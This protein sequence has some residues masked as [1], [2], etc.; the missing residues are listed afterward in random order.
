MTAG[1]WPAAAAAATSAPLSAAV[2]AAMRTLGHLLSRP[3]PAAAAAAA[4]SS[5]P[6]TLH[7][8]NRLLDAFARD[9]D[10]DA[11]LR[12]LRRMRHS[13]PACA[14]TAA[15][16]TSAMSALAKAGRPADAAALFDDMLANGVAPDRCA[17]SFL[18]HVYSSHLHLPSAAHSVLVWMSRLGLP[19]TPIDYA[20]LV[21]SF[22]RAGRLPD[23]LQLLDEMR[24]LN[25]PLTLHSYTPIL[26]VYCANADMQSADALISSMRSTGCHP[27]VVFY[28]IYVNGL[29]KV[30]DFDAVQRTIDESGRNGWVP[31]AVTYSTYIAGLCWFGYVEEALRQ[32]EIMVTMG[33]QPTVVGLN[34]LLDYVAQDLDMWAG[35]EVLERCQEL[36]FV[37][38]VVTYNTVMDHFCKKR[39]WLRVL[40]LFTDLLKKPITP[41]VQTC[42]I[43]ISCL[44]RAG[45][46]QFAKFVFSSKGFM[47]DTVTCNILIHAFYEAGKEDE[48][49]FLFA[50]VNAGKIAPDTITYNTLVDCLF[51]SG[52]RAEAVN[53]IRHIDDGYPVEPVA[54]LAYWLVRSGNVREALRLFDD[55]LEKG[56]LLDS[57]IFANVIKAFCRK[58]PGECTEML[59]LCSVLDRMLGIG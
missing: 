56:L 37:V 39:K 40:K 12:V 32:L 54:R 3:Q 22:C 25:Y 4:F 30:G 43:F 50:D 42:N 26:Q 2:R 21:F 36:G 33:L 19:P 38:D 10:G 11:A 44:C 57:R 35:K 16:Y 48:L 14:P 15:S 28:N 9:G 59:Q 31:D 17:F 27:D 1:A 6:H 24:A 46:F 23:A 8:Y 52:R 34:I 49:G 53:L 13:S 58:G 55:M 51:R 41:N 29:C 20:D 18:L 47:A 5:S 45:K 7:D